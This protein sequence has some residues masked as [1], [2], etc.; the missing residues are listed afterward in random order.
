MCALEKWS[1]VYWLRLSPVEFWVVKISKRYHN[2][3]SRS[4]THAAGRQGTGLGGALIVLDFPNPFS[5]RALQQYN[6]LELTP[7]ALYSTTLYAWD[8]VVQIT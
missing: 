3:M 4:Q 7:Y 5:D 8:H 2:C 6:N 1:R